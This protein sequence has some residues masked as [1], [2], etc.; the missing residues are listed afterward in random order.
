MNELLDIAKLFSQCV[1]MKDAL[2]FLFTEQ[3]LCLLQHTVCVGSLGLKAQLLVSGRQPEGQA[4]AVNSPHKL[5][6]TRWYFI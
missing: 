1:G 2:V 4:A 6:Q 5:R 3:T